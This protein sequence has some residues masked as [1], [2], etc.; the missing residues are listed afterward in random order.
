MAKTAATTPD[1]HVPDADLPEVSQG[2]LKILRIQKALSAERLLKDTFALNQVE[3]LKARLK[4]F[5]L[6]DGDSH[7]TYEQAFNKLVDQAA[8][9]TGI[10]LDHTVVPGNEIY[11]QQRILSLHTQVI[12]AI[13]RLTIRASKFKSNLLNRRRELEMCRGIFTPFYTMAADEEMKDYGATLKASYMKSFTEAQFS[14]LMDGADLDLTSL[15]DATTLF[16]TFLKDTAKLSSKKYD[17]CVDQVNAALANGRVD[18]QGTGIEPK[19]SRSHPLAGVRGLAGVHIVTDGDDEPADDPEPMMGDEEPDIVPAYVPKK[20]S[21]PA[22][23]AAVRGMFDEA[24][25]THAGVADDVVIETVEIPKVVASPAAE[26][27]WGHGAEDTKPGDTLRELNGMISHDKHEQA[28]DNVQPHPSE[29]EHVDPPTDLKPTTI[30]TGDGSITTF[31]VSPVDLEGTPFSKASITVESREGDEPPV[32]KTAKKA[33]PT[34]RETEVEEEIPTVIQK[35]PAAEKAIQAEVT[36]EVGE[37]SGEELNKFMARKGVTDGDEDGEAPP[38]KLKKTRVVVDGD[39]EDV[40]I[41]YKPR[42]GEAK[43]ASAP[44]EEVET[45]APVEPAAVPSRPLPHGVTTPFVKPKPKDEDASPGLDT[46]STTAV[47]AKKAEHTH[48]VV[49]PKSEKS[50]VAAIPARLFAKA[51]AKGTTVKRLPAGPWDDEDEL[52]PSATADLDEVM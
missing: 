48:T 5:Y 24:G 39:E 44:K 27:G 35:S 13:N 42:K 38:V 8:N 43:S 4:S 15:I 41:T 10:E 30:A 17:L 2:N 47:A 22:A 31:K 21:K 33:T 32:V 45:S 29:V 11:Y 40:P 52:P 6:D 19:S 16:I 46:P 14:S 18:Y 7:L 23:A 37:V 50:S 26:D 36:A 3:A 12:E 1:F 51:P 34:I 25:D 20:A 9:I 49:A 28:M